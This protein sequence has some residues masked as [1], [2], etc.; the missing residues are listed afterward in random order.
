MDILFQKEQ[1]LSF[2]I[3]V[4]TAAYNHAQYLHRVYDSLKVQSFKNFEWLIVDDCSTDNTEELIKQWQ[5]EGNF[6]PIRYYKMSE[7]R[8]HMAAQNEGARLAAYDWIVNIDSDD[9][10]TPDGLYKIAA[11]WELLDDK[12]KETIGIVFGLCIDQHGVLVGTP[13]P[14]DQLIA[15]Y[16]ETTFKYKVRGEKCAMYSKKALLEY[17]FYDKVDKHVIHSATYFDMAEKYTQYC[18]ND[19]VRVYYRFEEGRLTNSMKPKQLRHIKGRQFYAQRRINHYI[20]HIQS[21]KFK[22]LT[23]ISYIRYS[24]H[25]GMGVQQMFRNIEVP[26]YKA[27]LLFMLPFGF[28]VVLLDR[29]KKR[30]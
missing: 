19:I 9:A 12:T 14:E 8:G 13:F 1:P 15:N 3:T 25:L 11:K 28:G 17:P 22:F 6:F 29:I 5:S 18:I 30:V 24:S 23:F 20:K 7:N 16:Y 21:V 2:Q 27:A 26:R 10:L 4:F